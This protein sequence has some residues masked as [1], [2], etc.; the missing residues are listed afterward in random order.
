MRGGKDRE[1][2]PHP[3]HVETGGSNRT[4]HGLYAASPSPGVP[5]PWRV[6]QMA[7]ASYSA[8]FAVSEDTISIASS[9]KA[10]TSIARAASAG[11]PRERM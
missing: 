10:R 8:A 3:R 9:R 2:L 5:M 6:H 7:I 11:M 4:V 1:I